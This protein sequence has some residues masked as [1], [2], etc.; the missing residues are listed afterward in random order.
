MSKN[1]LE[2]FIYALRKK[3]KYPYQPANI[4]E[5]LAE[6][7]ET[8]C[9]NPVILWEKFEHNLEEDESC[10]VLENFISALREG[11]KKEREN[12]AF[13]SRPPGVFNV[14]S[15]LENLIEDIIEI[16]IPWDNLV[17]KFGE[18]DNE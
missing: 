2:L 15:V 1:Y 9:C 7:I 3:C 16:N 8:I 18:E 10:E 5:G 4:Q 14:A 13:D 6:L 17:D 11:Y 12:K